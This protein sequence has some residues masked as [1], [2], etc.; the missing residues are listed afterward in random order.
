MAIPKLL[1]IIPCYNEQD[2][3][4][5]TSSLFLNKINALIDNNAI[6]SDSQIL[7]V[8]DGSTDDTWQI[9]QSLAEKDYHFTGISLSRNKGHQNALMA[10]LMESINKCDISI[11]IDCDGQDDIDAMDKMIYEY[12]HNDCDIVYG[13][14]NNR[15]SDTFFKRTTALGFYKFMSMLGVDSVYNHADYRLLSNRAL[16]ALSEFK[17]RNMFIRGMIPLIG[18]KSTSVEY[19]RTE[20]IAGNTH[21]S[22]SKMMD[23]AINGITSLSIKPIRLIIFAGITTLALSFIGLIISLLLKLLYDYQTDM[24]IVLAIMIF[25]NGIQLAA[26]GVIGEYIGRT[27]I[28]TKNRPRYIIEK[29]TSHDHKD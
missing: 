23:L 17:E 28:E 8:N 20:R 3:L 19:K 9:I 5:I 22:L 14:R 16:I 24:Y 6:S 26:I 18:F 7:F 4:P 2:V 12:T 10:G 25:M 1:I 13:V 27:Y 11:S 29:R 21:Y 15:D